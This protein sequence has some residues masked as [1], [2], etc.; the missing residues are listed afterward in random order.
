MVSANTIHEGTVTFGG[1]DKNR[2][3]GPLFKIPITPHDQAPEQTVRFW[4]RAQSIGHRTEGGNETAIDFGAP[5]QDFLVDSGTTLTFLPPAV[6]AAIK[7][8]IGG[9]PGSNGDFSINC[10]WIDNPP[11]GGLNFHFAGGS[12]FMPYR[13]IVLDLRQLGPGQDPGCFLGIAEAS[14]AAGKQLPVMGRKS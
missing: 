11:D 1:I 7:A 5:F 14:G 13:K 6:V 3:S 12:I 8:Q 9:N 4:A 10:S 2:F